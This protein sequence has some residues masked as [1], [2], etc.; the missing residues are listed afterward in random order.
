MT[1]IVV[2]DATAII[3]LSQV[4]CLGLLQHLFQKI[5][6]PRAVYDEVVTRGRTLVSLDVRTSSW[7]SVEDVQNRAVVQ[8][9]RAKIDLG[10][11]EAI[12]LALEKH[13]SVLVIDEKKGRTIARGLGQNIIGVLGI[14]VRAK[15][16][17]LIPAVEPLLD[18]L[19]LTG[20]QV[21]DALR[22]WVLQEAGELK[23]ETGA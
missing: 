10:E 18:R 2:S 21:S 16:K 19:V 7:I 15:T 1:R 13:A 11:S 14:L 4:N 9:L 17:G 22:A 3:A 6:I 8:K 23:K 12:A 20:F 5:I